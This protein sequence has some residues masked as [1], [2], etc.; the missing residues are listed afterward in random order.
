MLDGAPVPSHWY[1]ISPEYEESIE[2][3]GWLRGERLRNR[4]ERR[5]VANHMNPQVGKHIIFQRA[6]NRPVGITIAYE[7]KVEYMGLG[8]GIYQTFY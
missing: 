2:M 8:L 5:F 3:E 4:V 1:T 6:Y 7:L